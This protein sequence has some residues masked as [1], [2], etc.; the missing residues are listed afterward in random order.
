MIAAPA[1]AAE[2]LA[3]LERQGTAAARAGMIRYGIPNQKAFGI[4]IGA[5]QKHAKLLGRDHALA[6]ALWETDRYEARLLAAYVDEP[7]EVTAAQMDRWARQFDS[8]AITD[9]VCFA[10]FD[11]TPHAWKKVAQWSKSR[12]EYVKRAAFALLASLAA[13]DKTC[14]DAPFLDALPLVERAAS[15]ERNFVKKGVIWALRS[16]GRRSGVLNAAAI[17]LAGR[18]AESS[19]P[20][21]RSVGKECLREL[22]SATVQRQVAARKT[23]HAKGKAT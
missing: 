2:V 3:W 14:G 23:R 4:A 21:E 17:E 11:R 13:H 12:E 5:L 10:L 22:N 16:L 19:Q 9:T 15:D 20:T 6:A 8:W 18:L 7:A 1:R